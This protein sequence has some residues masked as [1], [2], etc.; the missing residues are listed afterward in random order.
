MVRYS[1]QVALLL[2][3]AFLAWRRGGKPEKQVASILV[4]M[5][6]INLAHALLGGGWTD[7]S[8][9]PGF[10]I[11]LDALGL[12]LIT[13]VAVSADRWWPLW[14]ASLQLVAVLAHVLRLID[15]QLPQL[16][17]IVMERWPFWAMIIVTGL[18]TLLHLRRKAREMPGTI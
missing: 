7:Y 4:G 14:V 18:G 3:V 11:A 10:R 6:A 12:L 1:I 9:L 5:H 17:Y 8:E 13:L 2:L 16:I 15:A